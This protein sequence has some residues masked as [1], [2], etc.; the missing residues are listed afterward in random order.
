[1][2]PLS[3]LL[4]LNVLEGAIEKNCLLSGDWRLPHGAG[5]LSV[6]RWHTV[7]QG[8]AWLDMPSGESFSLLPATVLFLP[9]N[10]AHRLRCQQTTGTHIVCGSLRLPVSARY[11]QT[12][13]PE[14]LA[15]SPAQNSAEYLWLQSVISLLQANAD[16]TQP[17]ADALCSQQ[18]A[19]MVTLA[20]R[21]WL[22]TA[23]AE[24]SLL[25]LL[26]HP[27]LGGAMLNMLASPASPWTVES[28]AQ[29]VHMSRASF[30]QLFRQVSGAT[31]LA[32]LTT[33]RLQIATQL[34]SRQAQP[35]V[36]IADAVGYAN[37]S[38]F[39][40]AFVRQFHCTPG[41]YRK[42]VQAIDGS[43]Q[44]RPGHN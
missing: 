35:I 40:K 28:L 10:S 25:N 17:G 12:A 3:K 32:V 24:K 9:H 37:E 38:S 4:I 5:D 39:H 11:F 36:N 16:I 22:S 30:A 29:Q 15:L 27:R 14:V 2:D 26:L 1:M 23:P 20:V 43:G 34:L 6:I 33:L 42:Q 31:P 41:E 8:A 44:D 21:A 19:S 18:C 7:T 13:L